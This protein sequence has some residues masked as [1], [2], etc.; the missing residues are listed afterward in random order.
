MSLKLRKKYKKRLPGRIK[1]PLN[2]PGHPNHTWSMDFMSDALTDGR[3]IRVF[4]ITDDYNREALAI[5][6]GVSFPAERVIRTL[7]VLE[8]EYGLPINIRVDNGPEFISHK[9]NH[10]C[11]E[12]QIH[13]AF[14]QPGKPTQNAYIE[15]FNRI[16][17]ED[18][19]DAYWFDDLE[20]LRLIIEKWRWDYNHNHP[21]SSLSGQS[22]IDHYLDAVRKGKIKFRKTK[23][24]EK[25]LNLEWSDNW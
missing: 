13:L 11:A 14:I 15:R 4:N 1:Q 12:K 2:V 23:N 3:K 17:R 16:F 5:E 18:V 21:H 20:Q 10:W 19:L 7:Q 25:K 9:L 24:I 8:E 6:V 22:P